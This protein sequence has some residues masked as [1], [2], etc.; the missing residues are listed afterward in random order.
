MWPEE[1]TG[2]PYEQLYPSDPSVPAGKRLRIQKSE[3]V[4]VFKRSWL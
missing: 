4:G 1:K 3:I 2:E